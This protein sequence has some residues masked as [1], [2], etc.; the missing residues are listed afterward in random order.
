M[1]EQ[2][3]PIATPFLCY[4]RAAHSVNT[5][6]KRIIIVASNLISNIFFSCFMQQYFSGY[7][8]L[9]KVLCHP[10]VTGI[11]LQIERNMLYTKHRPNHFNQVLKFRDKAFEDLCSQ[12]Q[13]LV[14]MA[15]QDPH[16]FSM[17][18]FPGHTGLKEAIPSPTQETPGDFNL[19]SA[20]MILLILD[21]S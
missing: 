1:N 3:L 5:K 2:G 7:K 13:L 21:I 10:K 6:Q 18:V 17:D 11:Q 4:Q 9:Q 19:L 14:T 12:A 8:T 16:S 15:A 20:S